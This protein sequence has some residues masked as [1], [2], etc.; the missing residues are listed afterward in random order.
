VVGGGIAGLSA[1][2]ALAREGFESRL[3]ESR[4]ANDSVDRGDVLQ[5]GIL[6]VLESLGAFA[7]IM[8][9]NP[10]RFHWFRILDADGRVH[11]EANTIALLGADGWMSH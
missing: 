10:L 4:T 8:D 6:P 2:L 11:F 3:F 7:A 5:P 9:R 1:A